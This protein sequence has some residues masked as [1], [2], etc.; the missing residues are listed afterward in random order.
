M[1]VLKEWSTEAFFS[2]DLELMSKGS[3]FTISGMKGYRRWWQ[4]WKPREW[5]LPPQ[6]YTVT[7]TFTLDA[8]KEQQ[9]RND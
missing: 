2:S 5:A 9:D 4:F 1:A 8:E 3:T 7:E 6:T